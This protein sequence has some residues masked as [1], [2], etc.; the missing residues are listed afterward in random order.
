MGEDRLDILQ[1]F[2]L[3]K[4]EILIWDSKTLLRFYYVHLYI[5]TRIFVRFL[6]SV[7]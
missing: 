6:L 3:K 1:E 5:D 2:C 7:H 4:D